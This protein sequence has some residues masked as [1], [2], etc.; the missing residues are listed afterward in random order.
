MFKPF[1]LCFRYVG[2]EECGV[3]I[4]VGTGFSRCKMCFLVLGPETWELERARGYDRALPERESRMFDQELMNHCHGYR[5][6]ELGETM[7]EGL[8]KS[9]G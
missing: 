6:R 1:Y 4:G 8:P 2:S 5:V 9:W 3:Q 7:A